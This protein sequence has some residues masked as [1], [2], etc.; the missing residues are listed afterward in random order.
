MET[1]EKRLGGYSKP[2]GA[3]GKKTEND[4][5]APFKSGEKP[6]GRTGRGLTKPAK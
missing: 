5:G 3:V 4:R 1:H 6:L 2:V